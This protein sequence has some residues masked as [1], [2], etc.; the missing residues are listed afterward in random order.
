MFISADVI[1]NF[2]VWFEHPHLDTMATHRQSG[3]RR[4]ADRGGTS[5]RSGHRRAQR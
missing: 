4:F 1:K 2:D 3:Q 5:D